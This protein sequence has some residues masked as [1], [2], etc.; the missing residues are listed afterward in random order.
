MFLEF[1]L[2]GKKSGLELGVGRCGPSSRMC[3]R[4]WYTHRKRIGR[5]QEG[6]WEGRD[7]QGGIQLRPRE[8]EGE[9]EREREEE[10]IR[11]GSIFCC[12]R[13]RTSLPGKGQSCLP[14]RSPGGISQRFGNCTR[15]IATESP[16]PRSAPCSKERGDFLAEWKRG[17]HKLRAG[18]E[19]RE[20]ERERAILKRG[21][22]WSG[23]GSFGPT[24]AGLHC[25]E[26][27]RSIF[28]C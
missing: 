3:C 21:K 13:S 4:S 19:Q 16:A 9:R 1:R 20:K 24:F 27:Q 10:K 12:C 14:S 7:E 22:R 6:V 8:R 11:H 2:I 28:A 25:M 15:R 5:G 26:E 18:M 23:N 17:R